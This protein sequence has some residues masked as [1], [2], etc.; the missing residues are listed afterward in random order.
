MSEIDV[1][2]SVLACKI[3]LRNDFQHAY[4]KI[5]A[6]KTA[7]KLLLVSKHKQT[8]KFVYDWNNTVK[9]TCNCQSCLLSALD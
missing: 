2:T 3:F 9:N 5:I 7:S 1:P 4:E 8:N 6:I